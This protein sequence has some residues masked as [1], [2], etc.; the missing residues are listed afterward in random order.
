[1]KPQWTVIVIDRGRD[2]LI[3]RA[4]NRVTKRIKEKR[5]ES[6]KPKAAEREAGEWAADLNRQG[7]V[8]D[9][10]LEAAAK[11]FDEEYAVHRR[12]ST[13]EKFASSLR[14]FQR[15]VGN[16]YVRAINEAVIADFSRQ[17]GKGR[18]PASLASNLRALKVFLRWCE[19]QKLI[20]ARPHI[21]MP[22]GADVAGGSPVVLEQFE[23]ML[24]KVSVVRPKDASEWIRF[25]RGLWTSG[26][27]R[28]EATALSWDQSDP[29]CIV[30][31]DCAR[32]QLK[33]GAQQKGGR[34]TLTPC[35]PEFVEL[36]RE[37]PREERTGRVFKL[38][39]RQQE[40]VS[41]IISEVAQKANVAATCHDLRR[42][43]ACRWS[44]KLPAQ[45]LRQLMRHKSIATTLTY[46]ATD[47][48]G[49]EAAIWGQRSDKSS[50][51][52]VSEETADCRNS[53]AGAGI[54]PAR[55]LRDTGF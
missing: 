39:V 40:R 17:Y 19:R 38:L 24:D 47:D 35:T 23:R 12:A 8:E 31:I 46:Y 20:T 34:E 30:D 44:R 5:S 14:L 10:R 11:R 45:A 28:S 33:I 26:M 16:P 55:P 37:T 7:M 22:K 42:S 52:R 49:L 54:E 50:D 53:V 32:P 29:V 41:K 48:C 6:T 27:R 15:L 36:L 51:T 3:L 18:S 13:R 21:E 43:F 25:L 1:M 9:V 4:R 2:T